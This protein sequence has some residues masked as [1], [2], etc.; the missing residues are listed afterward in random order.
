VILEGQFS[1]APN[2][3]LPAAAQ[4]IV[5]TAR[6]LLGQPAADACQT[7]FHNRGIL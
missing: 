1:F 4:V 7:A 2:T 3:K 5:N 6:T